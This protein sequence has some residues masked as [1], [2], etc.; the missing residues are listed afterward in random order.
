[1][2]KKYQLLRTVT[3]S[4]NIQDF[5]DKWI[6]AAIPSQE[7][8]KWIDESPP[9]KEPR[10]VYRA[11]I[12]KKAKRAIQELKIGGV[13]QFAQSTSNS[14]DGV[15]QGVILPGNFD[16]PSENVAIFEIRL[17]S[18]H[19][20]GRSIKHSSPGHPENV[21][22]EFMM[23]KGVKG[24]VIKIYEPDDPGDADETDSDAYW[25]YVVEAFV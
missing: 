1:M 11:E 17:P 8:D 21:Q 25:Y 5:I 20:W 10:V 14:V 22:D 19:S 7:L 13:W 4:E 2:I 23:R 16:T 24:R 9:L 18:G 3:E 6:E 12:G 15:I